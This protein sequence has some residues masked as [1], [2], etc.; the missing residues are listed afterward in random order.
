MIHLLAKSKHDVNFKIFLYQGFATMFPTIK[1]FK[2]WTLYHSK[3]DTL[4]H[5]LLLLIFDLIINQ[6]KT[7]LFLIRKD[8]TLERHNTF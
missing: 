5:T 3:K 1:I 8:I 4:V 2:K 7:L 6:N